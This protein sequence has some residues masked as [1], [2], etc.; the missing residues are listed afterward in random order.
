MV[1][2]CEHGNE[3]TGSNSEGKVIPM[4]AKKAYGGVEILRHSLLTLELVGGEWSASRP[5]RFIPGERAIDSHCKRRLGGPHSRS[6]RFGEE[7]LAFSYRK[8][9]HDSSAIQSV[10]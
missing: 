10:A 3:L 4:H 6:G 1:G 7:K 8:S 9:N 2:F 5:R